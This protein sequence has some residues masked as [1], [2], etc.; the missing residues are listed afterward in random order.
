MSD[1]QPRICCHFFFTSGFLIFLLF[2]CSLFVDAS[3]LHRGRRVVRGRMFKL[4]YCE[5]SSKRTSWDVIRWIISKL[6]IDTKFK[7]VPTRE[8]ISMQPY[9]CRVTV[10]FCCKFAFL[11]FFSRWY[12]STKKQAQHSHELIISQLVRLYRKASYFVY[13][14]YSYTRYSTVFYHITIRKWSIIE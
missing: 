6:C 9:I 4:V 12:D 14:I 1:K 13:C 7:K 5:W 8:P 11:S 2:L 3:S 10:V